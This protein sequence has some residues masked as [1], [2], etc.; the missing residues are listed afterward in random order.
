[1]F[2]FLCQLCFA[3][4][5]QLTPYT[6]MISKGSTC[7]FTL[8][9]IVI[10]LTL[11]DYTSGI[12]KVSGRGKSKTTNRREATGLSPEERTLNDWEALTRECLALQCD[13]QH[14]TSSGSRQV[15]AQRLFNHY[16]SQAI[17]TT[18][19]TRSSQ[20][21]EG[22]ELPYTNSSSLIP[23]NVFPLPPASASV[24]TQSFIPAVH[25]GQPDV[26]A[27]VDNQTGLNLAQYIQ[28]SVQ[29]A[30]R[31]ALAQSQFDTLANDIPTSR[32][33]TT[34][35]RLPPVPQNVLDRIRR[36]EFVNLQDLL[37]PLH[38]LCT[39][40]QLATTPFKSAQMKIVLNRI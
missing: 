6:N 9:F 27:V 15:L 13:Q 32:N 8:C 16:S 21:I 3:A 29:Q 39:P 20:V 14:L 28:H 26:S 18:V 33:N 12:R 19:T 34:N 10:I 25:P 40:I 4:Y 30:V 5:C 23:P 22:S 38:P 37:P 7:L 11:P 1:M 36:G 31:D 35:N 2:L 17:S 24:T